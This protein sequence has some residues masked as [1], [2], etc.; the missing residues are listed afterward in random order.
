MAKRQSLRTAQGYNHPKNT[1]PSRP[2]KNELELTAT[3]WRF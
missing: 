2:D 3:R 1:P